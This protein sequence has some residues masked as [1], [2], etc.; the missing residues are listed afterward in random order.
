MSPFKVV[1][2]RDPPSILDYI[3][4]SAKIDVVDKVL[5]D[6]Q[7]LL[8]QL[9]L[10]LSQA[11]AQMKSVANTKRRDVS[12]KVG[13]YVLLRLQPYRQVTVTTRTS[14]KLCARYFGPFPVVKKDWPSILSVSFTPYSSYS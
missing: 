2:G 9:K 8:L 5:I 14:N 6:R 4:Q 13:D 11:Q 1:Y 7:E 3:R 12:F 10:N